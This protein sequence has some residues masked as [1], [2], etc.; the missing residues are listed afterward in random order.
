LE[1]LRSAY[2]NPLT[3]LQKEGKSPR[4]CMDARKINQITLPDRAKVAPMQELLQNFHGTKYITTLDLS[5]AFLQV[6][7]DE[8]SRKFTAFESVENLSIWT[9]PLWISEFVGRFHTC[10]ANGVGKR[11]FQLCHELRRRHT[12]IFLQF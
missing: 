8:A 11:D 12:H 1:E 4:I 10:T 3:V 2:I 7:L 6:P 9:N 5:S